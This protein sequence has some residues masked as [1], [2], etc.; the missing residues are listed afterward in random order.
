MSHEMRL[1][2]TWRKLS[3]IVNHEIKRVSQSCL[4]SLSYSCYHERGSVRPDQPVNL[5]FA[6]QAKSESSLKQLHRAFELIQR[7]LHRSIRESPP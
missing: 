6:I 3:P 2:S 7:I 1:A 5:E 4:F